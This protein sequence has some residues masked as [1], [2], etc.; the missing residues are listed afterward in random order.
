MNLQLVHAVALLLVS[1]LV[2]APSARSASG[3]ETDSASVAAVVERYHR[4]LSDADSVTAL[5]LLADDAVILE[6]GDIETRDEYRSH[7]L[8]ADIEFARA[9]PSVRG[10]VSVVTQG[11]AAWAISTATTH[12]SYRGRTIDS[13]GA[14]LMVVTRK[15]D[16]W[17]IRAI[18]WSS[19]TLRP[20]R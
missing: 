10:P 11:G 19:H 15:Q 5:A 13:Q 1:A 3:V 14:E 12:G 4:A 9:V 2:R 7:H 16:G 17:K 8:S 6:S 18:H 20:S